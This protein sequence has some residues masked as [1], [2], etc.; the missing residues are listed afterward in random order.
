MLRV[1]GRSKPKD[2]LV[3]IRDIPVILDALNAICHT[4]GKITV[5]PDNLFSSF[6][7]E[8]S[9]RSLQTQCGP[10]HN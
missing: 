1:W 7:L 4:F 10:A 3:I 6:E 2:I 9:L 8:R 5:T